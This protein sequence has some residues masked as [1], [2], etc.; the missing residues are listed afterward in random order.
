VLASVQVVKVTILMSHLSLASTERPKQLGT[1]GA[2]VST[3]SKAPEQV[4]P[5]QNLLGTVGATAFDHQRGVEV[6]RARA[7]PSEDTG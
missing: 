7:K 6:G 4:A 5:E 2:T 3:T 1:A